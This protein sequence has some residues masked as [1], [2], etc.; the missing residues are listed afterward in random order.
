MN[1]TITKH[2]TKKNG[3]SYR[4]VFDA[5][6]KPD[7]QRNQIV[8]KG[9]ATKREAQ[10]ALRQAIGDCEKGVALKKDPRTFGGFFDEWLSHH[11][12]AHWGKKTIETNRQRASYA[13]RMFGDVPLQKL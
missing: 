9:F 5:G 10:Q 6:R 11:G 1:G 2:T 4:Y 13:L 3:T 12:A 7:G 8:R